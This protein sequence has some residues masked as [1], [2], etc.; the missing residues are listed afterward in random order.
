[1]LFGTVNWLQKK[2]LIWASSSHNLSMPAQCGTHTTRWKFMT[3]RW[4][5]IV[6]HSLSAEIIAVKWGWYQAFCL[7]STLR[8]GGDIKPPVQTKCREVGMVSSL[9][10]KLS[11]V[12]WGWYRAFCPNSIG[13][14]FKNIGKLHVSRCYTKLL[15]NMLQLTPVTCWR[16]QYIPDV[17]LRQPQPLS[18][19]RLQRLLQIFSFF[20]RRISARLESCHHTFVQLALSTLQEMVTGP[21]ANYFRLIPPSSFMR[22]TSHHAVCMS[23]F[24]FIFM[25]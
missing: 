4:F 10:S 21:Q 23:T 12:K 25:H 1:M 16:P 20:P 17:I 22:V 7:N 8:S 13:H 11:A 24:R 15:T 5:S 14:L 9:L 6:Q 18:I 3:M 19:F 2:S